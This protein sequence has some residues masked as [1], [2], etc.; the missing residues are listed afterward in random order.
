MDRI[1]D[2]FG[3]KQSLMDALDATARAAGVTREDF[4]R[5]LNQSVASVT[6]YFR[7]ERQAT[8]EQI[9]T[10]CEVLNLP[11][12]FGPNVAGALMPWLVVVETGSFPPTW[13]KG[14]LELLRSIGNPAAYFA[15]PQLY[16]MAVNEAWKAYFPWMPEPTADARPNLIVEILCNPG[17]PHTFGDSWREACRWAVQHLVLFGAH[18]VP[19]QEIGMLFEQCR[20]GN[21]DFDEYLITI[22]G[23]SHFT[24]T[25]TWTILCPDGERRPHTVKV[26]GQKWQFPEAWDLLTLTPIP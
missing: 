21:P 7:M 10:M 8:P 16:P 6:K 23:E 4:A 13:S 11:K 22:P 25:T 3:R 12:V 20:K 18:K 9:D 15:G 14:D 17:A 2:P 26:L 24:E 1:E 5:A 19:K